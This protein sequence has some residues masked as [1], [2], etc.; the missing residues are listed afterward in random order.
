[1]MGSAPCFEAALRYIDRSTS[2][3]NLKIVLSADP[4]VLG[5]G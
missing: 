5:P 2:L 3:R 1:M 4:D